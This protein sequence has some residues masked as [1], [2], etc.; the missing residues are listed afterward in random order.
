MGPD[1]VD[2][3]QLDEA[4]VDLSDP[5]VVGN[6]AKVLREVF[7]PAQ[8]EEALRQI[9]EQDSTAPPLEIFRGFSM[10]DSWLA[11]LTGGMEPPQIDLMLR[12]CATALTVRGAGGLENAGAW[13][14]DLSK[15]AFQH[16]PALFYEALFEGEFADL[17]VKQ[18]AR[19]SNSSAFGPRSGHPDVWVS[20]PGSVL[21]N[22]QSSASASA[23]M[24]R[25]S[26]NSQRWHRRLIVGC[27]NSLQAPSL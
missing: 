12:F 8:V 10:L 18:A 21:C 27:K 11:G 15:K 4:A 16:D 25:R 24:A 14:G 6:L 20:A 7:G 1:R 2:N 17:W 9:S 5:S 19:R 3:A 22:S 23:H 13:L 26:G